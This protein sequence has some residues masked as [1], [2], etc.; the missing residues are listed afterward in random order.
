MARGRRQDNGRYGKKYADILTKEYLEQEY[1]VNMRSPYDLAKEH[2]CS[3]HIIYNYVDFHKIPRI[4]FK[5]AKQLQAGDRIHQL[6]LLRVNNISK[7]GTYVWECKCVCGNIVM[8]PTSR[9]KN[10]RSKSCGCWRARKK[11]HFWKGYC[12]VSGNRI[13]E[14]RLRAK[15]KGWDFDLDAEF[16]W[17]LY[18]KQD[19][20]CAISGL[21]ITMNDNASVDRIDSKQGYIRANVWWVHKDINKMKM[22][23]DLNTFINYCKTITLNSQEV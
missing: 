1:T 19:K 6:E 17:N 18:I 23:L 21:P 14:I 3:P 16:L 2:D 20:K 15:K 9:I 8:I 4:D 11:N 7:N 10:G 5:L 13:S 22:D 12:D